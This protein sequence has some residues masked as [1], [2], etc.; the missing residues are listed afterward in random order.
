MGI[1]N[2]AILC[3]GIEFEYSE[4]K[5]LKKHDDFVKMAEDIGTDYMPNLWQ[6]MGFINGCEY[7]DED[8]EYQYYIIGKKMK[9]V[10]TLTEFLDTINKNDTVKYIK[11]MCEKYNLVYTEP[12]IMVKCY[13]C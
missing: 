6:E 7:Y 12:K 13:I 5:H 2:D 3:Y 8:E 10:M 9:N 1:Q 4:I 11:D